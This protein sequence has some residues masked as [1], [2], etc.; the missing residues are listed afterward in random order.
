[1]TN[2]GIPVGTLA[3]FPGQ[4]THG[5]RVEE[6]TAGTKYSLIIWTSRCA[7]DLNY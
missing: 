5:H 4:V 6:V 2:A 1:M 7:G 3:M